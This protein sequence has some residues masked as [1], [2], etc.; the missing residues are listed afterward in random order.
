MDYQFGYI[1]ESMRTMI[2]MEI[3][4]WVARKELIVQNG[5]SYNFGISSTL[6]DSSVFA[7][8]TRTILAIDD[9]SHK[10][11]VNDEFRN[12][13]GQRKRTKLVSSV[14]LHILEGNTHFYFTGV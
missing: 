14:R 1:L 7:G 8:K 3:K 12:P 2:T 5:E 9:G 13:R 6:S 10:A 4:R 11:F